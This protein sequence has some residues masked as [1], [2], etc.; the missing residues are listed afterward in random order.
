[1][2]PSYLFKD[3]PS[4]PFLSS[5]NHADNWPQIYSSQVPSMRMTHQ[6]AACYMSQS[7]GMIN[8]KQELDAAGPVG[9]DLGWEG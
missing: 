1:M 2:R 6:S 3:K 8:D 7:A 4:S 5:A 9:G